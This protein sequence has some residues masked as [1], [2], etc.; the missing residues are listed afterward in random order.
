MCVFNFFFRKS[1][2]SIAGEELYLLQKEKLKV[3]VCGCSDTRR[4]FSRACIAKCAYHKPP[5][6]GGWAALPRCAQVAP[7][8]GAA[9]AAVRRRAAEPLPGSAVSLGLKRH[10]GGQALRQKKTV[11]SFSF[12]KLRDSVCWQSNAARFVRVRGPSAFPR[13]VRGPNALDFVKQNWPRE[14]RDRAGPR[15]ARLMSPMPAALFN[16]LAH[17]AP[18]CSLF[19]CL[20]SRGRR[21]Q[22]KRR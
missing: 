5:L 17:S 8:R 10:V 22:G 6:R 21:K 11:I 14:A 15:C 2:L 13:E 19:C 18:A 12:R 9:L 3:E 20:T 7:P 16:I 4:A 1:W